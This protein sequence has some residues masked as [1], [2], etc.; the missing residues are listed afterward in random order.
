MHIFKYIDMPD[1]AASYGTPLDSIAFLG[2]F[3]LNW[4]PYIFE[5]LYLHQTFTD[6]VTD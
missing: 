3:I 1:V 5:L 6:C 4:R 2:I